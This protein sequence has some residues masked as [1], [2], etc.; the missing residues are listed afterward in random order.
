M[1][2][3]AVEIVVVRSRH[4]VTIRH[5]RRARSFHK[6]RSLLTLDREYQMQARR[7]FLHEAALFAIITLVGVIWPTIHTFQVLAEAA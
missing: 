3:E 5:K 6:A 2:A 1:H 7:N 4:V